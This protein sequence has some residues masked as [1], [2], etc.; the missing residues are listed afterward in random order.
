[1]T[2]TNTTTAST[3]GAHLPRMRSGLNVKNHSLT[4]IAAQQQEHAALTLNHDATRVR[5]FGLHLNHNVSHV[6]AVQ[7]P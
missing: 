3:G 7:K 6:K 5:A 1:M 2:L 4:R